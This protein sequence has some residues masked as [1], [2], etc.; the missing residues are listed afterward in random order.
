MLGFH[1]HRFLDD[2]DDTTSSNL[3]TFEAKKN[4]YP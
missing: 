3:A 2:T 4:S 1:H